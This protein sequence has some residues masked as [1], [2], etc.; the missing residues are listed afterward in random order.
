MSVGSSPEV[1][2]CSLSKM[3]PSESFM[4]IHPKVLPPKSIHIYSEAK[5]TLRLHQKIKGKLTLIAQV[6]CS[7]EL[8][9]KY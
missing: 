9:Q 2:I 4:E 1:A 5:I 6:D 3:H 8:V 7:D